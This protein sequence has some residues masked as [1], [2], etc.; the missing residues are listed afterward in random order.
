V[1][2]QVRKPLPFDGEAMSR[3]DYRKFS[4]AEYRESELERDFQ[5]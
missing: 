1:K 4:D 3:A 2:K 5:F